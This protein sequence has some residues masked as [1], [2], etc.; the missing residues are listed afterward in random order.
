[1]VHR[2]IKPENIMIRPDGYVKVLDFGI[3]KSAHT[4][5]RT[6]ATSTILQTNARTQLGVAMG[7]VRYMSPE[8]TRAA[9]VDARSDVWSLGVVLYEMLTTRA[10]FDGATPL[11]VK[12]AVLAKE[13]EPLD[14]SGAPPDLQEIIERCLHKNPVERFQTC[15]DLL[16]AL[17][18]VNRKRISRAARGWWLAAAALGITAT[19]GAAVYLRSHSRETVPNE[20]PL[21]SIAVLP[22]ADLSAEQDQQYFSDGMSEEILNALAH[23]KDLKVAGRSSSFSFRGRDNDLRKVAATL[24][25]AHILEGSVR[26]QGDRVRITAQLIQASDGFHLWSETYDGDLRDVFS[27]QE[28]IARAITNQLQVVL[29]GE[30]KSRLVKTAT[31]SSDAYALYLQATAVFNRRDGAHF[32]DAIGQLREAVRLDPKFARAHARLASLA[33]IAPQY[34]VQLDENASDLLTREAHLA[35]ELDPSLAE[36]H[37]AVGQALFTQRHFSEARAAYARALEL[38]PD[39]AAT[40]LWLGTLL[41]STGYAK[42]SAE[43]LDKLLARDPV[44]PNALLW[45]GWTHLQLGEI[46]EAERSIR[47]AADAGLNFVGLAFA[48]IALARGDNAGVV[49]WLSRGLET[50]VSDLPPRTSRVIAAATVGDET[51]RGEAIAAIERY[52]GTRPTYLSGAIPLALIWLGQPE[53]ALS[54]AQ[55]KPTRNDTVL[56]A[57]LW[58]AASRNART[59][60]QFAPFAQRTG[61]AEFWDRSGPPDLC[62]KSEQ[63]GYACDEVA[64]ARTVATTGGVIRP[65]GVAVGADGIVY[66]ADFPN[67][68]I[69][70]ISSEG[71]ARDFAGARGNAGN[72]DGAGTAAR[73]DNPADVATGPDGSLYVADCNNHAIR[74]ITPAG[75]VSTFA[76]QTHQ[77]GH[78][79]GPASAAT[80]RFPTGLAVDLA[81]NVYV[82]DIGNQTIR[83]ITAAGVVSTLAGEAGEA[84]SADG[85]GA[86]ARFN[87][88][89]GVAVDRTGNV[90]AADFGNHTIRKITPEGVVTTIGGQAGS[91]GSNDGMGTSARFSAP[92][93]VAIDQSGNVFVADTSNHTIRKIAPDGGVSTIAGVAGNVGNA[94]GPGPRARFAIPAAV[95]ADASGNIYVADFGNYAIRKIAP[96]GTVS[97]LISSN[98]KREP[99]PAPSR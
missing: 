16:A 7:T 34:D 28:R 42:A 32:L 84:G 44:L 40:N 96:D 51:Q 20:S 85:R 93:D 37:A 24:G 90:Y 59:S 92:Y 80:F 63:G 25:V 75:V 45:R 50:F 72:A 69:C 2:D 9:A 67:H 3:A 81:G 79:D 11:D 13:P 61:L 54:V 74:K 41:S 18:A 57:S 52:L 65:T 62:R 77:P 29:Q 26:K 4:E 27:L 39:D 66:A 53:R 95:K 49:D 94:D 1:I 23:V 98:E 8:Q 21:K 48:H 22:F 73:F 30:Q 88:A 6:S 70:E 58:T 68:T 19:I 46:D 47:Q 87:Q 38:D 10:P 64:A 76:G 43:V 33:S 17:R 71:I 55:D 31:T 35:S 60:P 12:A 86:S 5:V 83:K 15:E 97:T 36:P 78:E 56:L 14:E 99:A 89:H 82:A 91:P